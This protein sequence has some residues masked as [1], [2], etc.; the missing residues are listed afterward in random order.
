MATLGFKSTIIGFKEKRFKTRDT[1]LKPSFEENY[2][3]QMHNKLMPVPF[4]A[5]LRRPNGMPNCIKAVSA[6]E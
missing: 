1:T 4:F 3:C 6:F 2:V 5:L